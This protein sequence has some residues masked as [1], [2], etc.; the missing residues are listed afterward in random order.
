MKKLQTALHYFTKFELCLWL[1]SMSLFI[2]LYFF[3]AQKDPL[4]LISSLLGVSSLIFVAK[5]NVLGQFFGMFFCILYAYI[6]FQFRYYGEMLTYLLMALPMSI[7]GAI[8]WL[9]HPSAEGASV[10]KIAELRPK[11]FTVI[12]LLSLLVMFLFYFLLRHFNTTN[13][14]VSTL[15]VMTSF[16]ASS[17]MFLRSPYYAIAYSANDIVLIALWLYA[18]ATDIAYLPVALCFVIFLVNDIYAFINWQ[19]MKNLQQTQ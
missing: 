17:L 3:G 11:Q 14:I 8:S 15:S 12:F 5:G 19:K 9:K 7:F 16:M 6:S 10:V 1:G 18:S 2:L 13:L 4:N